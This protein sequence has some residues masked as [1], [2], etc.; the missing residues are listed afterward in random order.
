MDAVSYL[1]YLKGKRVDILD[2]DLMVWLLY[3]FN[4]LE[5]GHLRLVTVDKPLEACV[6]I[7]NVYLDTGPSKDTSLIILTI[8]LEGV[9][10]FLKYANL[11]LENLE[12]EE[13]AT[14]YKELSKYVK[15]RPIHITIPIHLN[16]WFDRPEFP[17]TI[18]TRVDSDRVHNLCSKVE[19]LY[20]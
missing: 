17:K 8:V 13:Y 18:N 4:D 14:M 16:T 19:R 5:Y 9:R 10:K 7:L 20:G 15:W 1:A 12:I 6:D 3:S 2:I 11:R